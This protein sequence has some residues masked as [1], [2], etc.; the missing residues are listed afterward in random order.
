M[1]NASTDDVS[2][3]GG[4]VFLCL[5]VSSTDQ[6]GM[7]VAH[8]CVC[9]QRDGGPALLTPDL[10]PACALLRQRDWA[11]AH[12]AAAVLAGLRPSSVFFSGEGCGRQIAARSA[13][14]AAGSAT[15]RQPHFQG[16]PSPPGEQH[17]SSPATR[18]QEYRPPPGGK[19]RRQR[20]RARAGARQGRSSSRHTRRVLHWQLPGATACGWIWSR[21]GAGV[22]TKTA[23]AHL[24]RCTR[25]FKREPSPASSDASEWG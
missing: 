8:Q 17:S 11:A 14:T 3:E 7:G 2:T 13:S 9:G 1:G 12:P 23:S 25:C 6:R 5:P 22:V 10:C 20:H 19:L 21:T 24:P 15:A 4:D 16:H 18:P